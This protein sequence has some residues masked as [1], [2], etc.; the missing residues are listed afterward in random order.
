[1]IWPDMRW[2]G[3]TTHPGRNYHED[4]AGIG[5]G[6]ERKKGEQTC[7]SFIHSSPWSMKGMG[8]TCWTRVRTV[9]VA[10]LCL[11]TVLTFAKLLC[12]TAEECL[13][14]CFYCHLTAFKFVRC[15]WSESIFEAETVSYFKASQN[16]FFR[17]EIKSILNT[18]AL[19]IQLLAGT[20]DFKSTA[21]ATAFFFHT[22]E[23]EQSSSQAFKQW[24]SIRAGARHTW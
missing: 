15:F 20:A 16:C 23:G 2:R 3:P 8:V 10:C 1:M 19:K 11:M 13:P 12:V 17:L 21:L 6:K 5:K 14:H 7:F 24:S 4:E 9:H 22:T 18:T